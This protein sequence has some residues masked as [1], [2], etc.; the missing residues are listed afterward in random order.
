MLNVK[1]HLDL[2]VYSY[3]NCEILKK[4]TEI[5]LI[6]KKFYNYTVYPVVTS[7]I[8]VDNSFNYFKHS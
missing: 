7:L 6:D 4:L 5:E 3:V 8:K 1:I 2:Y